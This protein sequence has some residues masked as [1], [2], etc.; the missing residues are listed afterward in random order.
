M[1]GVSHRVCMA[2]GHELCLQVV[3]LRREAGIWCLRCGFRSPFA[4]CGVS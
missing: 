4:E 1:F 3:A 2:F